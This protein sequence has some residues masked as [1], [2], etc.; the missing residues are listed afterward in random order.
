M[1]ALRKLAIFAIISLAGCQSAP[2]GDFCSIE[3]ATRPSPAVL[4]AM[5]DAEVQAALVHN[6][7]GEKLCGWKQ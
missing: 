6:R 2:V 7:T 5:T 3:H 4:S 1:V